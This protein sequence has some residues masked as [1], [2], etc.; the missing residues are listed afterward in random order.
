MAVGFLRG[1]VWTGHSTVVSF[2]LRARATVRS[3]LVRPGR[4]AIMA[5]TDVF[6]SAK[7]RKSYK[8]SALPDAGG[9]EGAKADTVAW[10]DGEHKRSLKKLAVVGL[11]IAA[12]LFFV[13]GY[14]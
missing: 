3:G 13:L 1:I 8:Y 2:C 10:K 7:S 6:D 14:L 11:H 4:V 9:Y 5:I 12:A